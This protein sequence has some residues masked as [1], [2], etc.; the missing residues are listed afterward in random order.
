MIINSFQIEQNA[1]ILFRNT[2]TKTVKLEYQG[3]VSLEDGETYEL[4]IINEQN[5]S[6]TQSTSFAIPSTSFSMP[7]PPNS[8]AIPSPSQFMSSNT[9]GQIGMPTRPLFTFRSNLFIY[10]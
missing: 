2:V 1:T 3:K 6:E 5:K 9:D 10:F 4:T 7:S 8:F